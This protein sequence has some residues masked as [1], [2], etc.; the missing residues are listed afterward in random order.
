MHHKKGDKKK[1]FC[2]LDLIIY[3]A[4][5]QPPS[6]DL[7]A[8]PQLASVVLLGAAPQPASPDLPA[9]PQVASAALDDLGAR[10]TGAPLAALVAF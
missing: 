2:R 3:F 8:A 1:S 10:L 4:P 5:P 6:L 7:V 9:A